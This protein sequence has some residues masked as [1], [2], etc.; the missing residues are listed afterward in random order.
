MFLS[1]CSPAS[2]KETSS[3]PSVCSM[4]LARHA[5]A[6]RLR[7][8][9]QA[10]GHVHTIPKDVTAVDNDV[11]DIDADAKLDP[12]FLRYT[13]IAF[14][15][16]ALNIDSTAHR[17]YNAAELSEQAIAGVLDDPSAMFA[18]LGSTRERR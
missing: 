12:L 5:D 2:S 3:L 9:F 8:P 18:I 16:A 1:A 6:T 10:C 13:G 17:V 15:H 11:P 4:H 7:E 14:G